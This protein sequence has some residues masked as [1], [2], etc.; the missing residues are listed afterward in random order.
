MRELTTA[1]STTNNGNDQNDSDASLISGY[2]VVG[3]TT[4]A[5]GSV[6]HTLD[7][8]FHCVEPTITST[9]S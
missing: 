7:F 5:A 1:N 4:G 8:G 6:D 9:K 2:A 3:V